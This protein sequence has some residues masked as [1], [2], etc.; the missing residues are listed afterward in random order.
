MKKIDSR[1]LVFHVMV[2]LYFIWIVVFGILLGM[3]LVNAYG[4]NTNQAVGMIF[5]EWIVANLVMGSALFIVIRLFRN[6]TL[7]DRI[8][9]YSYCFMAVSA[10]ATVLIINNLT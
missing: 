8:V 9:F 2:A 7:L 10:I 3:A 5:V 4:N 6:R 1:H